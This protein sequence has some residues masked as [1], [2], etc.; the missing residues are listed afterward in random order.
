VTTT[1]DDG[2]AVSGSGSI[3]GANNVSAIL[4][5]TT[6]GNALMGSGG[7]FA[8]V[9]NEA[10]G[11]V[12]KQQSA[13]PPSVKG[14][15]DS[16]QADGTAS[17]DQ[18]SAAGNPST[19]PNTI[20]AIANQAPLPVALNI[21]G[22]WSVPHLPVANAAASAEIAQGQSGRSAASGIAGDR[23]AGSDPA[24]NASSGQANERRPADPLS[25]ASADKAEQAG[26]P[27]NQ[28]QSLDAAPGTGSTTTIPSGATQNGALAVQAAGE[29]FTVPTVSS[30]NN[31]VSNNGGTPQA[32]GKAT[33]KD[34]SSVAGSVT[35][36]TDSGAGNATVSTSSDASSR[37]TQSS[38]PSAL[39]P[40]SDSTQAAAAIVQKSGD[41]GTASAQ[42][43]A[44]M[45]HAVSHGT[46]TAPRTPDAPGDTSRASD[47]RATAASTHAD[48]SEPVAASGVNTAKL[49]QTMSESEMRVGMHSSEFGE[50][51]IRTT[52][53]QQ[54]MLAQ[55]SL[56]HGDLGQA[57][58]AHVSTLQAK[59]GNDYGL[60][61]SIQ[62]NHQGS[63]FS[64]DSGNSS[65]RE[66]RSFSQ[67]PRSHSSSLQVEAESGSSLGPPAT[68]GNGNRL[69]IRA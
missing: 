40:Q 54:Q 51:S 69:D 2:S 18:K 61:A 35:S 29:I 38:S 45:A 9:A 1:G 5:R 48:G 3:S 65:P 56:D 32:V 23:A 62:I 21:T 44:V 58:A 63:S 55:I 46:A 42:V 49:M 68:V 39:H 34:L 11:S 66:Q 7:T 41:T 15:A 12:S 13:Q 50:I 4:Y 24:A 52:V 33:Q 67:S 10:S 37:V 30:A 8:L 27:S 25:G 31:A 57:M 47:A 28:S 19:D 22:T 60:Q 14:K 64:G 43:Q 16:R 6:L 17:A 59:L 20:A 53:S 36:G 26:S